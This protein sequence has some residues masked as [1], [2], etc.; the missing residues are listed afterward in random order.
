MLRRNEIPAAIADLLYKYYGEVLDIN[1]KAV[2]Q[3]ILNLVQ[4]LQQHEAS[5]SKSK[6]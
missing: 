3:E 2:G 6:G 4:R 1:R 5:I